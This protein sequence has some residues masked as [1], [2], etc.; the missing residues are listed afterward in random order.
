MSKAFATHLQNGIYLSF[1]NGIEV[2]SRWGYGN[3]CENYDKKTDDKYGFG[4]SDS[5]DVEVMIMKGLPKRKINYISKR[6]TG[7]ADNPFGH[8]T[9]DKWLYLLTYLSKQKLTLNP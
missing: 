7:S 1:P 2:S 6:L 8:I 4:R 3:Y 9:I 5:N